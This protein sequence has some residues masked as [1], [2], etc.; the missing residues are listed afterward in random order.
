M[1]KCFPS[2]AI[3]VIISGINFSQ[4]LSNKEYFPYN[5]CFLGFVQAGGTFSN[6]DYSTSNFSFL[7][8]FGLEYFFDTESIHTIG[9]RLYGGAGFISGE[10]P[11]RNIQKYKTDISMISGGLQYSFVIEKFYMPYLYAGISSLNFNPR[12]VDDEY[13]PNNEAGLYK[14]S[15]V[16]F[17][18]EFGLRIGFIDRVSVLISGGANFNTN[19]W[20]DDVNEGKTYDMFM[21]G[22]VGFSYAFGG[23]ADSDSDGIPDARDFCPDTP[24]GIEVDENGCPL[25]NDG[26]NVPDY[27]DQ[28]PNTPLNT[29]VD[30]D[31]CPLDS[32]NDGIPNN[33]DKCPDTPAGVA[34]D[35]SGCPADSDE[36][37]VADYAD[38]CANTPRGTAVDENGCPQKKVIEPEKKSTISGYNIAAEKKVQGTIFSDGNLY[39][40]QISSWKTESKA[41]GICNQLKKQGHNAYVTKVTLP[42]TGGTWYR[43]RVGYFNTLN[44]AV[45]YHNKIK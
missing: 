25:D 11:S 3:L 31:G 30:S 33:L 12:F 41:Q 6:T 13:M 26:D 14:K 5:N 21:S 45:N 9:I 24:T 8:K 17:D 34:I 18:L 32:D 4:P 20:L 23:E 27:L 2:I 15:E 39:C 44:D 40:I 10:D 35:E 7:S 36:D 1:K 28:C 19:D 22:M 38:N 42:Q 16:N 29:I 37:G 43:V